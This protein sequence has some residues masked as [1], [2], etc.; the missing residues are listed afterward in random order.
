MV[1]VVHVHGSRV[2]LLHQL[3]LLGIVEHVLLVV[4][5]VHQVAS[6]RRRVPVA[7]S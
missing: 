3:V 7:G 6:C 4:L 5:T 2:E 1:V